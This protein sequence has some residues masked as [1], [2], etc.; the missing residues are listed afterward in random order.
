[1][2]TGNK[3][4]LRLETLEKMR[5]S[6]TDRNF[7]KNFDELNDNFIYARVGCS[8]LFLIK[9]PLG[10]L[11][12]KC[13]NGE[14]KTLREFLFNLKNFL[15][16]SSYENRESLSEK[17]FGNK[18]ILNKINFYY[19][20]PNDNSFFK[21][22]LIKTKENIIDKISFAIN[23]GLIDRLFYDILGLSRADDDIRSAEEFLKKTLESMDYSATIKL[24]DDLLKLFFFDK[25]TLKNVEISIGA[26]YDFKE[27]KMVF[28]KTSDFRSTISGTNQLRL[29]S[30]CLDCD[31][32]E[33]ARTLTVEE[34]ER[35]I[36]V[37]FQT[38]LLDTYRFYLMEEKDLPGKSRGLYSLRKDI[39]LYHQEDIDEI[40]FK[41]FK[42]LQDFDYSQ[43]KIIL[44]SIKK[45]L[46]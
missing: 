15:E 40:V 22:P 10:E 35:V 17:I 38:L 19:S 37:K 41:E 23:K 36:Y 24:K 2:K 21:K 18:A 11:F 3:K 29:N 28:S 5:D 4:N 39:Q 7:S 43:R 14:I 44:E 8:N 25:Q 16:E 27:S 33:K 9:E 34:M 32:F 1:M 45:I 26:N 6:A 42:D 20:S 31:F 46:E 12:D 30:I 13:E